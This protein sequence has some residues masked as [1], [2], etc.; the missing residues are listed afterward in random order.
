MKCTNYAKHYNPIAVMVEWEKSPSPA[1]KLKRACNG[2]CR[3]VSQ[4]PSLH[5]SP[6][7]Y[8]R[9]WLHSLSL[10]LYSPSQKAIKPC[11][12]HSLSPE[13][14]SKNNHIKKRKKRFQEK[15]KIFKKG[16][17]NCHSFSLSLTHSLSLLSHLEKVSIFILFPASIFHIHLQFH[18]YKPKTPSPNNPNIPISLSLKFFLRNSLSKFCSSFSL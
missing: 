1:C 11:S 4:L 14:R 16:K 10:S 8:T 17:S 5:P 6:S 2:H 9:R 3:R 18:L 7:F 13:P 12:S 15:K